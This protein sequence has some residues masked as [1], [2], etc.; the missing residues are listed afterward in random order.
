MN[1]NKQKL[2][3]QYL[4]SSGDLYALCTGIVRPEYFA[5]EYRNAVKFI[6]DYHEEYNALPAPE[7]I[8]AETEISLVKQEIKKDQFEYCATEI[9]AFCKFQAFRAAIFAAPPL[10]DDGNYGKALRLV[11]DAVTVSL[12]RE[13]G[14]LYFDN[15]QERIKQRLKDKRLIPTGWREL[16]RVLDGGIGRKELLL[17][18]GNS[19]VGKSITMANLGLNVLL[20]GW[21]VL[22]ITLEL[23]EEVVGQRYD[24]MISRI[25]KFE[26]KARLSELVQKIEQ[27]GQRCGELVI[28]YMPSGSKTTAIKSYLKEL[29]L[30]REYVPDV[31]IVDYIDNVDPSEQVPPELIFLHDKLTS[32]QLRNI[33]VEYN[34]A[35][36]TASQQNREAVDAPI[37]HQ[38]HIAGGISKVNSSDNYF[39]II[40]T[41]PMKAKG[42]IAFMPLKTRNSLGLSEILY[43]NW[44]RVSLRITDEDRGPDPEKLMF[45]PKTKTNEPKSNLGLIDTE[46]G[47]GL[48]NLVDDLN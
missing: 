34:S 36:V 2:L 28:K 37:I 44:D 35:I 17:F 39:T 46:G 43:H 8:K 12:Q 1:N 10:M 22:Y 20:Q 45:V 6:Q 16:D 30:T 19:G 21:N 31:I 23:S 29:Q 47:D 14:T 38:G 9:E 26:H 15:P 27:T 24:L 11:S 32:E 18:S 3:L 4:I 33:G 42:S 48:L 25:S 13:I 41:G 7:Q 40:Q 5:P